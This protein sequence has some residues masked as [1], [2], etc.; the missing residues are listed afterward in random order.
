MSKKMTFT[1]DRTKVTEGDV[2]EVRWDCTGAD[3]VELTIDNGYKASTLPLET[4]GTKRFRLNR[5]KGYTY[6]TIKVWVAGKE[7][8]KTLRV[9]VKAI[10]V[11]EAETIDEQGRRVSKLRQWWQSMQLRWQ[12]SEHRKQFQ[13]LPPGKRL[14]VR[15]ITLLT[16]ILLVSLFIP[17]LISLMLVLLIAYLLWVVLKK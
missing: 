8:S 2:V 11:T 5:S 4:G 14:A 16:V 17:G 6:L 1:V 12:S 13:S 9:K 3:R 15:I 7:D 10:P